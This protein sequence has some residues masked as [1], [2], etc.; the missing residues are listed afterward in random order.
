MDIH[1]CLADR[2]TGPS[3]RV[4]VL[5][6]GVSVVGMPGAA[7]EAPAAEAAAAPQQERSAAGGSSS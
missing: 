3:A 4:I 6:S 5:P 2:A 7:A 1:T